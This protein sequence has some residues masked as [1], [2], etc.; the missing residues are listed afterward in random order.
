MGFKLEKVEAAIKKGLI[1]QIYLAVWFCA[2]VFLSDAILEQADPDL[3]SLTD[4]QKLYKKAAKTIGAAI[5]LLAEN[6]NKVKP[7]A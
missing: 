7:E 3:A 1:L 4:A 2:L 6:C 5:V